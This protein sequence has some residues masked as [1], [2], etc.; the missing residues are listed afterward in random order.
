MERIV[1]IVFVF[2]NYKKC[3]LQLAGCTKRAV[4]S[5]LKARR[6]NGKTTQESYKERAEEV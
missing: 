1:F 4:P 2:A 3:C 5:R 6:E